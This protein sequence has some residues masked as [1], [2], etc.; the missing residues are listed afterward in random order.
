[1]WR[2]HSM[3]VR[4][5]VND[6]RVPKRSARSLQNCKVVA[7]FADRCDR[8]LH[9]DDES[10]A[11]AGT[12]VVAL[13][14]RGAGQHDVGMA[15]GRR[16]PWIV[17]DDRRRAAPC[18]DQ[19]VEILM[20]VKRIAAA[21]IDEIDIGIDEVLSVVLERLTRVE[22]QVRDASDRDEAANRIA[23]ERQ[24]R[25]RHIRQQGREAL[26]AAVAEAEAAAGQTD[27]AERLQPARWLPKSAARRDRRAAA[28]S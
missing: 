1:M 2:N 6:S 17:D 10:V 27:L 18:A 25:N 20:M 7:R 24:S 19:A 16:P 3:V 28:T 8:L 13:E 15:R 5:S 26:H 9:R 21:P 14:G 22:Q 23:A 4:P 12:D 11:R